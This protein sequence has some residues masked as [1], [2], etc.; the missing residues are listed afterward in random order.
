MAMIENPEN[1]RWKDF[2][3]K[4]KELNMQLWDAGT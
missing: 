1:M 3:D 4:V 2:W